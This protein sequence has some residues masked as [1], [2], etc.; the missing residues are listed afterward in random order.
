[1]RWIIPRDELLNTAL[2]TFWDF[3]SKEDF[4]D[5]NNLT[6]NFLHYVCKKRI[7][8]DKDFNF[9]YDGLLKK[10]PEKQAEIQSMLLEVLTILDT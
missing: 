6:M 7:I 8:R 9:L 5:M 3:V 10:F 2:S 1:M 4:Q